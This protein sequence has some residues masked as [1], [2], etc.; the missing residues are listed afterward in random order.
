MPNTLISRIA[1]HCIVGLAGTALGDDECRL[2]AEAPPAGIILFDR[3]VESAAQTAALVDEA[4]RA[5]GRSGSAPLLVCADHE[6]GVISVLSRAI[7]TPPS[8]AA[9]W[10]PRDAGL[11]AA[12]AGETARRIAS[13]GVN[14]VLAPLADIGSDPDNPV[15][16]TR[17]FA[18]GAA[19]TAAAVEIFVRAC[20]G[21]GLLTCLKHFPGHGATGADSHLTLPVIEA[22]RTTLAGRELIPF[23]AGIAAGADCVMSAHV[24]LRGSDR[25]AS[26]DPGL[27][28]G[29]LRGELGFGGA[30]ITDALEMAGI[31]PDRVPMASIDP[32][33]RKAPGTG[34]AAVVGAA[35][36][37]GND[38]LLFS[39]P[40]TEA[41]GE[42]GAF[43]PEAPKDPLRGDRFEALSAPSLAR[44][45]A[46]RG[47]RSRRAGIPEGGFPSPAP[48]EREIAR[49]SM[50]IAG[51]PAGALRERARGLPPRLVLAGTGRDLSYPV[52]GRFAARLASALGAQTFFAAL[53]PRDR[54][55]SSSSLPAGATAPDAV[56][57]FVARAPLE[58]AAAE[59]LAS[60]AAVVI[61]AARP[62]DLRFAPPGTPAIA[63]FGVYDAAA[64][65]LARLLLGG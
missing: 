7:G 8:P 19:E 43:A 46:L 3:N 28:G 47:R 45:A 32:R 42:L 1:P 53:A 36:E 44:I 9:A 14:L 17:A 29:L 23:A 61:A 54:G 49:R 2:L 37:A 10:L 60:G 24:A 30:V 55:G 34:P 56:L 40:V 65:E 62:A 41:Y 13:C 35:L 39:S 48:V 21:E 33:A 64:D 15:I 20:A 63:T 51:D 38:L 12:C 57:V 5:A 50:K 59:A 27:L 11:L 16:G 18:G 25:P 22:D 4:R 52:V 6:G 26:L 58:P 31:L